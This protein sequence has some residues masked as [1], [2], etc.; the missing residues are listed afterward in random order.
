M[1]LIAPRLACVRGGAAVVAAAAL[2]GSGA[3]GAPAAGEPVKDPSTIACPPG[4]AGWA[5]S[6]VDGKMVWDGKHDVRLAGL[7]Q[8]AVNCNYVTPD[9]KHIEVSVAYAL[10]TDINPKGDFF[11]GCSSGELPWTSTDRTFH[12]ISRNQWAMATFND[13]LRQLDESEARAFQDVTRQLLQNADGYAH[14]CE[15][16]LA[17]TVATTRYTF[18][19]EAVGASS[20]GS[21]TTRG[22]ANPATGAMR[23][24]TAKAPTFAVKVGGTP[25][26]LTVRVR[27]GLDYH[28]PTPTTRGMLRLA[29]AVVG[30]KL[31]S[32]HRG[33]TGTLTVTTAPAVRLTVCGKTFLGGRAS[34]TILQL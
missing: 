18:A 12:V 31:A 27:R 3:A 17:P 25:R 33:A 22:Q 14:D 15:L 2:V 21:F 5:L 30:S 24:V 7:Q 13:L 20:N 16:K 9:D 19:F 11:Y 34:A 4:P 10:P 28:P 29:V 8:V 32:C 26:A 1:Q 23:V 6:P